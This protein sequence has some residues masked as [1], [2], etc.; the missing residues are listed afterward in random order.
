M[1]FNSFL[2]LC[3]FFT[4]CLLSNSY[5]ASA[6]ILPLYPNTEVLCLCP[7]SVSLLLSFFSCS[8]SLSLS[9]FFLTS[10]YHLSAVCFPPS[11]LLLLL[12]LLLTFFMSCQC[13]LSLPLSITLFLPPF[14]SNF[15]FLFPLPESFFL[16]S[17]CNFHSFTF[18]HPP[19]LSLPLPPLLLFGK[20]TM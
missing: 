3:W 9:L 4:V 15:S 11:L 19:S 5:C 16:F 8:L 7:P 14:L 20:Q 10:C 13:S 12:L 17:P 18:L 1:T 2:F 6:V